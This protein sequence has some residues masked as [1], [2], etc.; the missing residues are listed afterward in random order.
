VVL[1]AL[2]VT[3]ATAQPPVRFYTNPS[4]PPREVLD[5]LNLTLAWSVKLPTDGRPDG[6]A[7]IQMI[8]GGAREKLLVQT[9]RGLV[10]L[11]DAE[12]GD[13]L[14]RTQVGGYTEEAQFAAGGTAENLFLIRREFVHVLNHATGKERLYTIDNRVGL[15]RFGQ[16][17]LYAATSAPVAR[18][19]MVF[20][21]QGTRVGGYDVPNFAAAERHAAQEAGAKAPPKAPPPKNGGKPAIP[22]GDYGVPP[23]P[24]AVERPQRESSLQ[25][26]P[27][28]ST[29]TYDVRILT[30]PVLTED[31]VAVV[32]TDGTFISLNLHNGRE[33]DRYKLSGDVAAPMGQHGK[34]VYIGTL[35]HVVYA[36]NAD[37]LTVRWRYMTGGPVH[38]QPR[39]TDAD[40]FVNAERW[41]LA[42]VDRLSGEEVWRNQRAELFL[43]ATHN[44]VY[45]LDRHGELLILDYARGTTLAQYNVAGYTFPYSNEQTDRV[46]LGAHDGSLI[47]L[48]HRANRV[49]YRV[50][51]LPKAPPPPKGKKGPPEKGKEGAKEPPPKEEPQDKGAGKDELKKPE[52][53]DK[54]KKVKDVEKVGHKGVARG[55]WCVARVV[56]PRR[57][58]LRCHAAE[59]LALA[60]IHVPRATRHA[61]RAL[62]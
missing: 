29:I 14:W 41:G 49:P 35:D 37:R 3:A 26:D 25:L 44:L 20:S 47:C 2:I 46:I 15:V 39:V 48:H 60:R 56:G 13:T 5:R 28:W 12:T 30:T 38:R 50:R 59:Q 22:P 58:A 45:A 18:G 17:V 24:P 34:L 4:P 16:P 21:A 11:L 32:G 23:R 52:L 36:L 62:G 31:T 6:L 19:D 27:V 55:A 57:A 43:A 7:T 10:V 9:R 61:P 53:P 40:V 8:S 33:R 42:R 51:A 1:G 54:G